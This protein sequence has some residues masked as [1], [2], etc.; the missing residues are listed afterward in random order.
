MGII[1]CF[2]SQCV[3]GSKEKQDDMVVYTEIITKLLSS[4]QTVHSTQQVVYL[5]HANLHTNHLLVY[6]TGPAKM[7]QVG[8]QNLTTF[9]TFVVS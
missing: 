1:T 9:F 5:A 3:G 4:R 8:T 2:L 7:D 6:V